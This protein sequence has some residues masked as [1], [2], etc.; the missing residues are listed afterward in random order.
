M[1]N[2][3]GN[4]I[5]R[6][7]RRLAAR[8]VSGVSSLQVPP[9]N[10]DAAALFVTE[11]AGRARPAR[12]LLVN[13]TLCMQGAVVSECKL[14]R[15]VKTS[16]LRSSDKILVAVLTELQQQFA[17][18]SQVYRARAATEAVRLIHE[19]RANDINAGLWPRIVE[20]VK[21]S[22]NVDSECKSVGSHSP[23]M[24]Q[25]TNEHIAS[26]QMK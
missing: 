2:R 7:R 14:Q 22:Y 10:R 26:K 1:S 16:V 17:N 5:H 25:V 11:R 15:A 12:Y 20:I 3:R 4:G 24:E 18:N 19:G 9:L 8:A 21:E 13:R 6:L 23:H